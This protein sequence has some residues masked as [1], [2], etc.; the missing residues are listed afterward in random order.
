LVA[1]A[2]QKWEQTVTLRFLR[3]WVIDHNYDHDHEGRFGPNLH[4]PCLKNFQFLIKL[5]PGILFSCSLLG[6]RSK[7]TSI[8][9]FEKKTCQSYTSI[10][11]YI[12]RQLIIIRQINFHTVKTNSC[13]YDWVINVRIIIRLDKGENKDR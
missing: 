3:L 10:F 4:C 6:V 11:A 13:I 8:S 2:I 12:S 5:S 1:L 7:I 9:Q